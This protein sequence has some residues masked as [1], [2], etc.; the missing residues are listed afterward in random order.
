MPTPLLNLAHNSYHKLVPDEYCVLPGQTG[1]DHS[2][3]K[4]ANADVTPPNK[5]N[6][7]LKQ[8]AVNGVA[9]YLGRKLLAVV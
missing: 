9:S 1:R 3:V 5:P 6:P 8:E 2:N 7:D 4:S